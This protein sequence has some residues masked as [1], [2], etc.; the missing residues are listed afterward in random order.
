MAI[1]TI[2]MYFIVF[3][4][5]KIAHF[6]LFCAK[7]LVIEKINTNFAPIKQCF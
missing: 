5:V 7:M 6:L 3:M 2:E 1:A 4:I